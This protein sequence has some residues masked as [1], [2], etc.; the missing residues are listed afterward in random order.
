MRLPS[1]PAPFTSIFG[2]PREEPEARGAPQLRETRETFVSTAD[3]NKIMISV[4]VSIGLMVAAG[5][6]TWLFYWT[7]NKESSLFI[8]ILSGLMF[9]Y[10]VNMTAYIAVIR[11]KLSAVAFRYYIGLSMTAAIINLGI[12]IVFGIRAYRRMSKSAYLPSASRDYAES[13]MPPA[14]EEPSYDPPASMGNS[15]ENN[16]GPLSDQRM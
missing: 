2:P 9:A 13:S 5:L 11:A 6:V 12:T 10:A 16:A 8:A 3:T 14:Y 1:I 15:M 7:F 4:G